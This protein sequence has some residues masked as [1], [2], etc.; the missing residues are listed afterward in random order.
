MLIGVTRVK[1]VFSKRNYL[2]Q[3]MKIV[4]TVIFSAII[5]YRPK[6]VPDTINYTSVYN[7]IDIHHK[8][9]F[10]LVG[11]LY[12]MEYG[13]FY[14]MKM[15]RCFTS[16][17]HLF[18]FILTLFT[19]NLT[20]YSIDKLIKFLFGIDV[21]FYI[22]YASY[23]SYY[24]IYYNG[25][26][27]RQGLA[28]AL[29]IMAIYTTVKK[30]YIMTIFLLLSAFITH[31]LAITFTVILLVFFIFYNKKISLKYYVG[32]WILTGLYLL[33][34]HS[35]SIQLIVESYILKLLRKINIVS[36]VNWITNN[37]IS[38]NANFYYCYFW[39]LG[40]FCLL[41]IKVYPQIKVLV[42]IYFAGII[43]S[44]MSIPGTNRVY[45]IFSIFSIIIFSTSFSYLKKSSKDKFRKLL[46]N[47]SMWIN[48]TCNFILICSILIS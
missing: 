1:I 8:Y 26:A 2:N 30:K 9:G 3:I 34:N 42:N 40:G 28:M 41:A 10:D 32:V 4:F 31:R 20:L 21:N 18:Y 13:F 15:F 45:D 14:L 43:I 23:I 22:L 33:L 47:I 35:T 27:I 19:T 39:M 16:N 5:A 48:I 6:A 11:E 24:G 17:V 25:I 12:N 46:F 37:S 7:L 44:L 38:F 29:G 36:Y